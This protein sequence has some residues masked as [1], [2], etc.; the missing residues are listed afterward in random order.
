M[1]CVVFGL[2]Q[3]NHVHF[4]DAAGGGFA[5]AAEGLK[6]RLAGLAVSPSGA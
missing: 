3:G 1:T 2:E 6:A 5:K 4:I